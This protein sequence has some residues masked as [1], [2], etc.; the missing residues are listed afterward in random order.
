MRRSGGGR[1]ILRTLSQLFL[2]APRREAPEVSA[3]PD[4]SP[5]GTCTFTGTMYSTVLIFEFVAIVF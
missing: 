2:P 5:P 4:H 1:G 3:L